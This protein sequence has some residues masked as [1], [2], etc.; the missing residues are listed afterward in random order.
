MINRLKLYFLRR[1][2]NNSC[3]V[4]LIT[5]DKSTHS[6]LLSSN[7]FLIVHGEY[8]SKMGKLSKSYFENFGK[9]Q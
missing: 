8:Y 9:E 5:K 2:A 3:L 6:I 4:F 7:D 1:K